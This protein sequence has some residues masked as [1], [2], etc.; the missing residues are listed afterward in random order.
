[1]RSVLRIENLFLSIDGKTLL[2]DINLEILEG[3]FLAIIGPNGGGKS[4][5]IRCI[6]GFLK[7][8]RG[9][10]YLWGQSLE[11]FKRWDQIGYVPQRAGQDLNQFHPLSVEEFI[12]LPFRWYK[13]KKDEN[14]LNF[15]CDKFGIKELLNKKLYQLSF[16]QLQRAYLVRALS[17]NPK[18]LILDEPSVGLDFVTQEIFYQILS[19]FHRRK[20]TIILITHETWLITKEVNKVACLNQKLYFHGDHEEF[21]S[22]QEKELYGFRFHKIEHKHW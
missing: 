19:E 10:I 21:C 11:A 8:Q 15:L 5:L 16:G 17:H 18:L 14:Y 9:N 12:N 22:F 1:M 2:E 3:D 4:T 6:L 13:L 20:L 7:P